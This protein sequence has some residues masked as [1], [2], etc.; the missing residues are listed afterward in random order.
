MNQA[1]NQSVAKEDKK[2]IRE[3]LNLLQSHQKLAIIKQETIIAVCIGALKKVKPD[4]WVESFKKVNQHP[5]FRVDSEQWCKRIESKLATGE[6]FFVNR[7]GLLD[8][9]P[10]F[11]KQMSSENWHA[12]VAIIDGIMTQAKT[13][14]ENLTQWRIINVL[15]LLKYAALDDMQQLQGCYH[16]CKNDPSFFVE[17]EPCQTVPIETAS[18]E[19]DHAFRWN[20]KIHVDTIRR[21]TIRGNSSSLLGL[22]GGASCKMADSFFTHIKKIVAQRHSVITRG[23][24]FLE[25]RAYLN[26]EIIDEQCYLLQP[27]AV[28]F[29]LVIFWRIVLVKTPRRRYHHSTSTFYQE[30]SQ[31]TAGCSTIPKRLNT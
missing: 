14:K 26:I 16:T 27:T 24:Q 9:M 25:P 10:A 28:N 7:V 4:A 23:R 19:T 30:A 12:V 11:W 31:A 6:S 3:L 1:Y 5:H 18:S 8:A 29:W 2:V 13:N 21:E 17:P 20:Q 22:C 15:K